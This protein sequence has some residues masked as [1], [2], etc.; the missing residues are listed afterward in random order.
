VL[1]VDVSQSAAEDVNGFP[2]RGALQAKRQRAPA[3]QVE[4]HVLNLS[5]SLVR[6]CHLSPRHIQA[7]P[8]RILVAS[9]DLGSMPKHLTDP[10]VICLQD[11]QQLVPPPV[12]IEGEVFI[13]AIQ[14]RLQAML[15]TVSLDLLV[16]RAQ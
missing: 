9:H 13:A 10:R 7:A 5:A 15:G 2:Y 6:Q 4:L 12:T 14:S 11:W 1:P 3:I 16:R 8:E